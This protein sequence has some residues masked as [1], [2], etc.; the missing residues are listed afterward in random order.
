VPSEI[1]REPEYPWRQKQE[2]AQGEVDG[3]NEGFDFPI[4]LE[5]GDLLPRP[6]NAISMK[7]NPLRCEYSSGF[8][9]PRPI[10]SCV[11]ARAT[12]L[13]FVEGYFPATRSIAFEKKSSGR[14]HSM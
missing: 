9:P 7:Y 6:R 10:Y 5:H 14:F 2:P 8:L 4:Q 12:I 13:R 1:G 3:I 11:A